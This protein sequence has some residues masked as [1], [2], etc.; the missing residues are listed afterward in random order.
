MTPFLNKSTCLYVSVRTTD[1]RPT[2]N[3]THIVNYICILCILGA[4]KL[5]SGLPWPINGNPDNNLE[6]SCIRKC[7]KSNIVIAQFQ[8]TIA[9]NFKALTRCIRVS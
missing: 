4:S 7:Y 5:L 2:N 1:F 6:S 8:A 3:D 9:T